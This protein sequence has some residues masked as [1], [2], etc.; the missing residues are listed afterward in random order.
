MAG[1]NRK[2]LH[3]E[4]VRTCSCQKS[5]FSSFP[6]T[7]SIPYADEELH[8]S[9]LVLVL[10]FRSFQLCWNFS[11]APVF[12]LGYFPWFCFTPGNVQY[13][14]IYQGPK[15]LKHIVCM[16]C[17]MQLLLLKGAWIS[18]PCHAPNPSFW[19]PFLVTVPSAVVTAFNNC[20]SPFLCWGVLFKALLGGRKRP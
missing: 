12:H 17:H 11:S 18:S 10:I 16:H 9:L 14:I 2:L 7:D 20:L 5:I 13:S 1:E 6:S 4:F 15:H 19:E 8:K 3:L